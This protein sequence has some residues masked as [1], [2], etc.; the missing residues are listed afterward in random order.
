ME[1]QLYWRVLWI[2]LWLSARLQQNFS[3]WDHNLFLIFFMMLGFDKHTEV[4]VHFV[5][6]NS[7]F[8]QNVVN[9][10]FLRPESTFLNFSEN[11]FIR[12]FWNYTW[13]HAL[14]SGW[15]WLFW[16]IKGNLCQA[17]NGV[18]GSFLRSNSTIF[19]FCENM[20]RFS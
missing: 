10:T 14:A 15:K 6:S 11:L 17:Q 12:D 7:S 19:K 18:D 4:T 20:I 9:G 5:E 8:V 3:G 16:I 13:R 1:L 2:M